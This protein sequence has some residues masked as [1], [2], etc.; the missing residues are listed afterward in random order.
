[1]EHCRWPR[2]VGQR[3]L[4]EPLYA[5][6][7]QHRHARFSLDHHPGDRHTATAVQPSMVRFRL[8][9]PGVQ[10]PRPG[11]A[12]HDNGHRGLRV[13]HSD[14]K[15]PHAGN[16]HTLRPPRA[17]AGVGYRPPG[18]GKAPHNATSV[19]GQRARGT[20]PLSGAHHAMQPTPSDETMFPSASRG[21]VDDVNLEATSCPRLSHRDA[22]VYMKF[23]A[24]MLAVR[25]VRV[26]LSLSPCVSPAALSTCVMYALKPIYI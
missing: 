21:G 13:S 16:K 22:Y 23:C 11:I 17:P 18:A 9:R 6:R 19:T 14:Y 5:P 15:Q 20:A 4:P 3:T 1:M 2:N 7:L 24:A 8:A 26:G 10:R 12:A 25:R